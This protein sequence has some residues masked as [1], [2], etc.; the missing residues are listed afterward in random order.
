MEHSIAYYRLKVLRDS[1]KELKRHTKLGVWQGEEVLIDKV[2]Y[3]KD[4]SK[5]PYT[6]IIRAIEAPEMNTKCYY[7]F[8][9]YENKT[10]NL[11]TVCTSS[12]YLMVQILQNMWMSAQHLHIFEFDGQNVAWS[13]DD[14]LQWWRTYA[15]ANENYIWLLKGDIKD[16]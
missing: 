10:L 14:Y 2:Q 13:Y 7:T 8:T 12:I 15:N 9:L 11:G 5:T 16:V 1:Y 3:H 6:I 4:N